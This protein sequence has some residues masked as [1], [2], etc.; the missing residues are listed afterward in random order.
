MIRTAFIFENFDALWT[1]GRNYYRCLF[2]AIESYPEKAIEPIIFQGVPSKNPKVY[3]GSIPTIVLSLLEPKNISWII[4]KIIFKIAKKDILLE[5]A[6][7]KRNINLVSHQ[8][9]IGPNS[10][11]KSIGWIP[12][13]QHKHLKENFTKEI[14]QARD[15][16]FERICQTS[17]IILVSSESA[18]N[19]LSQ[20]YPDYADKGRVLNFIGNFPEKVPI[21]LKNTQD[22]YKLSGPYF[23]V[24]NQFWKHKNH[25]LIID[26]L[27]ILRKNNSYP[28]IICSG[29][30][31]DIN[32]PNHF[33]YL[34]NKIEH[35]NL[36]SQFRILGEIDYDDVISLTY[37]ALAII[38][39]SLFEGWSTIVE[40]VRNLDRNLIL[41]NID[42]HREQNA[43]NTIYVDPNNPDELA[44]AMLSLI[45]K[46]D[47]IEKLEWKK[48]VARYDCRNKLFARQYQN[49][50]LQATNE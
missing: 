5:K 19:D 26:A 34:K 15:F 10:N 7:L 39:P 24:P 1:G 29:S 50:I 4:R 22:K 37:H 6:L 13:F 28:M 43:D 18:M 48:L 17:D 40:E 8:E 38:N 27:R 41:S 35:N 32:N 47:D 9:Y 30:T 45:N 33:R 16:I 36:Q 2:H 11:I 42:V 46:T 23:Y 31:E 21:T 44:S 49:I 12:D 25:E 3:F 14:R 20:F